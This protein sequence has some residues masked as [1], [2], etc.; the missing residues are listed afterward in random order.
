MIRIFEQRAEQTVSGFKPPSDDHLKGRLNIVDRVVIDPHNT[1]YS[2]MDSN[3]MNSY[4]ILLGDILVIDK[5]LEPV[6]GTIVVKYIEGLLHC[7]EYVHT[8]PAP[9]LKNDLGGF[10]FNDET[11]E[12]WGVVIAIFRGQLPKQLQIGRYKHVCTL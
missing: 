8:K 7:L 1:F 11:L 4:G 6:D 5:S 3:D 9:Y 2:Q 12:I 10:T